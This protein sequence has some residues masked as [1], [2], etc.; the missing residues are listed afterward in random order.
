MTRRVLLGVVIGA[1]G[2]RG[3]VRV[4]T[5]TGDPEAI[6]DYGPLSDAKAE[7]QFRLKVRR[8]AKGD[9]V[10]AAIQGI[11]D[12]N[13]AEA[14][15][16]TELYVPRD[17]LPEAGDGEFYYADL[18]GLQAFATDGRLLGPVV[19]VHNFG[20]GDM[21]EVKPEGRASVMVPFTDDAVPEVDVDG[22]K[23]TVDPAFW[24]GPDA[25]DA[26]ERSREEAGE[27]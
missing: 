2:I 4:K 15:K 26:A 21:L 8:I 18:V 1:Q 13:A 12:R 24:L 6:G 25:A 20:A 22:G 19:A 9:V 14:L 17:A 5:F 16:G 3:E 11:A 7:R 27:P 10:I 23:V